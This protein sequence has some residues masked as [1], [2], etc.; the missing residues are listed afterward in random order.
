MCI[1]LYFL[2]QLSIS[3]KHIFPLLSEAETYIS[4]GPGARE[5]APVI[6]AVHG[7]VQDM[8]V[9]VE[10]RLCA[11]PMVHILREQKVRHIN[12]FCHFS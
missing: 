4:G 6:I 1:S 8:W 3:S 5:E 7:D 10:H 11:V 2:A 9:I 12:I